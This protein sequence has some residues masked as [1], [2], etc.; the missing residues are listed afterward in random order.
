MTGYS[1]IEERYCVVCK[2]NVGVK[3]TLT[4][5]GKRQT[6]CLQ[7]ECENPKKLCRLK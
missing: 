6:V 3:Y 7:P 1:Y 5:D 4:E 2:K